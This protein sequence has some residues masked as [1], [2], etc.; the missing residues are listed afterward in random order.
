MAG[1][2]PLQIEHSPSSYGEESNVQSA[3][4]SA[5]QYNPATKLGITAEDQPSKKASTGGPTTQDILGEGTK[6]PKLGM[7]PKSGLEEPDEKRTLPNVQTYS[8]PH[9]FSSHGIDEHKQH[10]SR[11]SNLS[12][13]MQEYLR[14]GRPAR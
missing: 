14:A 9:P 11:V 10:L 2:L 5:S 12:P 3:I 6:P 8:G 4:K 7:G 13:A 1:P